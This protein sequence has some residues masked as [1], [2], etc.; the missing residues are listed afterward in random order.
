MLKTGLKIKEILLLDNFIWF[1]VMLKKETGG[2]DIVR[3]D[4]MIC[5][6][7]SIPACT[8]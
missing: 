5:W 3:N 4:G 2:N 8:L 6:A 7:E 1:E